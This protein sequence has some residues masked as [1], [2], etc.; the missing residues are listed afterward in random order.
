MIALKEI[1]KRSLLREMEN[2]KAKSMVSS[3]R[4]MDR[5][6]ARIAEIDKILQKVA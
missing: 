4:E 5:R 2:L 1:D 3:Q 6:E